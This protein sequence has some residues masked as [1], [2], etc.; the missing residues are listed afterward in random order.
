[1]IFEQHNKVKIISFSWICVYVHK[2][3]AKTNVCTVKSD[4]AT[5]YF[6]TRNGKNTLK[7]EKKRKI[8]KEE[9]V[10]KIYKRT[11]NL[12]MCGKFKRGKNNHQ[13]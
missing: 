8:N 2:K 4:Y 12:N 9:Y 10:W 11:I 3:W 6:K 1:M 5:E 13:S 7:K